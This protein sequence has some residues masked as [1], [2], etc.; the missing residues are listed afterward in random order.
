MSQIENRLKALGF[1]LPPT[2][3][4]PETM[5]SYM[6]MAHIIGHRCIISGHAALNPDGSIAQPLGQVGGKV[7]QEEAKHAAHLTALA[8]LGTLKATLG[9][10]DRITAWV[11]VLGMVNAVPGF[12]E[13][14]PV[15]NGFSETITQVFGPKIGQ[16][17]RSAVG[18]AS[19]PFD[20]P[21]EIEAEVTFK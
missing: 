15:I 16:H 3:P 14:T 9:D 13:H 19:L 7:T 20:L 5:Q 21:V 6:S 11:K 4:V 2:F 1:T 8:M 17:A 10:L 18:M 12:K